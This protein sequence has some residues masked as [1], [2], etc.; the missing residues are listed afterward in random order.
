MEAYHYWLITVAVL[1]L[2]MLALIAR[3]LRYF[4]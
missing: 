3:E 2:V 4:F 1:T